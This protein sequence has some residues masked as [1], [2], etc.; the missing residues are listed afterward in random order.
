MFDKL[1]CIKTFDSYYTV[2]KIYK[3]I[4]MEGINSFYIQSN[5]NTTPCV[6]TLKPELEPFL[7]IYDYFT[8]LEEIRE[9]KI[10]ELLCQ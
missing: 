4:E 1:V 7:S 9:V 2:G 10:K 8:S 3:V 6:F 5:E